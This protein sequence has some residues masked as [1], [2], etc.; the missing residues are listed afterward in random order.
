MCI[1]DSGRG[2]P[3]G[4]AG[5]NYTGGGGGGKNGNSPGGYDGGKGVVIIRRLT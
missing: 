3:S 1:R 2:G 4:F 5:L